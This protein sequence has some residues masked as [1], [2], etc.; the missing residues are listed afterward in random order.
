MLTARL[1]NSILHKSPSDS[2]SLKQSTTEAY[3]QELNIVGVSEPPLEK[4]NQINLRFSAMTQE[5]H[6]NKKSPNPLQNHH[7]KSR[8]ITGGY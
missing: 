2:Y 1:G 6:G 7:Q 8:E 4:I 5:L 3:V